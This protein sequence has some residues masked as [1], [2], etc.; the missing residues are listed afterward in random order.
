MLKQNAKIFSFLMLTVDLFIAVSSFISAYYIRGN[1]LNKYLGA[2]PPL[3]N[4]LQLILLLIF[5]LWVLIFTRQKLYE[6]QRINTIKAEVFGIIK[7][8]VLSTLLVS[9]FSFIFNL[10]YL[11]RGLILLFAFINILSAILVR[12]SIRLFLR[13]IRK[14]GYNYRKFLIVGTGKEVE[15]N[16]QLVREFKYWG[17]RILGFIVPGSENN[18]NNNHELKG[19][20]ILGNIDNLSHI[21]Y[22][23]CVDGVIVALPVSHLKNLEK[24]L[25]VCEEMG[26][27]TYVTSEFLNRKV[28]KVYL[29]KF[30][31]LPFISFATIPQNPVL[32]LLKRLIDVVVSLLLCILLSPLFLVSALAIK[33][34]SPGQVL[35]KQMRVGLYGRKFALLKFRTMV[36]NAEQLKPLL[37]DKNEMDGPVFKIK[38]DP[39]L[40][41]V[42]KIL[43]KLSLD[44]L[45]QLLNVLKG[46][47]SLVGPR[48][49]LPEEVEK[50]ERWQIRRLSVRPGITCIWQANGRNHIKFEDWMK[51]D[52]HY[53]DNWSI[54][55]DFKILFKTMF[56]VL[57]FKG[58]Y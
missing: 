1:Y 10:D 14:K 55:L 4:H 17:I 15:K 23:Q 18:G 50:Y 19:Y 13:F 11:S 12:V 38:N 48:P 25:S 32:I 46:D 31:G 29:E 53:I 43:R 45:P 37:K 16:A 39:R 2:I 36:N 44:E 49:P 21:L 26:I 42:G 6:S 7:A 34:T 54:F 47:M 27:T 22:S 24:T 57:I 30:L 58:A 52:L 33:L 28:A 41:K 8:I 5:P 20:D 56:A 3:G 51:L 35:F 9:A 40:T